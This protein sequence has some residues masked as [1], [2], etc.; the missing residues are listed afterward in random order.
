MSSDFAWDECLDMNG[1]R[2]GEKRFAETPASTNG[3]EGTQQIVSFAP[4][5]HALCLLT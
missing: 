1:F 2:A 3:C 5:I 4:F